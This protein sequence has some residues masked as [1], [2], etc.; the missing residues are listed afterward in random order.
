MNITIKIVYENSFAQFRNCPEQLSNLMS[1]YASQQV[2]SQIRL[3]CFT[4]IQILN[5]LRFPFTTAAKRHLLKCIARCYSLK[6][7]LCDWFVLACALYV[8]AE[9]IHILLSSV[10]L[11][12]M[13][14]GRVRVTNLHYWQ[15]E[16]GQNLSVFFSSL[17]H[18]LIKHV[19]LMVDLSYWVGLI[20]F[21]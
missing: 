13:N 16:S 20:L 10:C 2:K 7:L 11:S 1:L 12:D 19:S 18:G 17:A 14:F 6:F 3:K 8:G 15:I 21:F 4:N 9:F 5:N